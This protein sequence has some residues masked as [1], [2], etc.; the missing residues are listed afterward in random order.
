MTQEWIVISTDGI[1]S[2]ETV[3]GGSSTLRD[4]Q[5]LAADGG[6]VDAFPVRPGLDA[7]VD[8]EGVYKSEL[9][10]V[11]T[12][13]LRKLNEQIVQP[14]H[15]DIVLTGLSEAG[16]TLSFPPEQYAD[17]SD[18]IASFLALAEGKQ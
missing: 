5:R 17:L 9:N 13:I 8:D 15:G 7:W 16:D 18:A 6:Y 12:Y 4:L 14:I 3:P 11:G 10:I 2:T 1:I